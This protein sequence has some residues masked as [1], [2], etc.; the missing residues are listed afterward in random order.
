MKYAAVI[1]NRA[2]VWQLTFP[3]I[4]GYAKKSKM[5]NVLLVEVEESLIEALHGHIAATGDLPSQVHD[6]GVIIDLRPLGAAKLAL[7]RALYQRGAVTPEAVASILDES[8]G[9]AIQVLDPGWIEANALFRYLETLGVSYE[10]TFE[11]AWLKAQRA[12]GQ[13]VVRK[14]LGRRKDAR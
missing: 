1:D 10:I 7:V 6:G 3:D 13:P 2:G 8:V 9:E 4:P 11:G 12:Q 14:G 5:A